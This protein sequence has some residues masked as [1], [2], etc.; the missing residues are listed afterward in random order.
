MR[1]ALTTFVVA[2]FALTGCS[3]AADDVNDTTTTGQSPSASTSPSEPSSP[4]ESTSPSDDAIEV[5]IEGGK[6]SPNGDRVEV[7]TGEAI[8]LQIDSDR[9]GE[10]HVHSTPE[11][12]LSFDKGESTVEL[13]IDTPGI[14]DV[15]EHET[16][17]VVLQLEVS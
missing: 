7:K 11:Q 1:R 13:T 15:E 10:L 16:G 4:S 9:A 6:I 14:V 17:V 3:N 12:E 2:A 5:E 8:T